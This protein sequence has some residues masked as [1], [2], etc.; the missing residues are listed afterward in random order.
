[1][2]VSKSSASEIN[3]KKGLFAAAGKSP[4]RV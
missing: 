4:A 3:R 2:T 1:V